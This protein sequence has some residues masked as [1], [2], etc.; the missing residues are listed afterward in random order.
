MIVRAGMEAW[1]D[2]RW[3]PRSLN[4]ILHLE[5]K[6]IT[7]WTTGNLFASFQGSMTWNLT[8]PPGFLPQVLA[9]FN[10]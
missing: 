2:K 3:H 9:T 7:M 6:M 4:R 1:R 10:I 5:T 8:L